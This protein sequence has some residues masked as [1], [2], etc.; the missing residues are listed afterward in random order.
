MEKFRPL[1]GFFEAISNDARISVAHIGLYAV[2]LHCWQEQGF[3]NPVMAFSHEIME[4][5][6]ISAR[7]TY[8]KCLHDLNEMGYIRYE[9][10]YKRN[11]RS[12]VFL[13]V[14]CG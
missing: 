8:L 7:A 14:K 6:K 2:L 11:N 4:K 9:R 12:K 5:A 1:S 3:E 10:S 13:N